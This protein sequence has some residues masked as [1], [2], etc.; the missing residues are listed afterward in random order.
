MSRTKKAA[1]LASDPAAPN[2]STAGNYLTKSSNLLDGHYYEAIPNSGGFADFGLTIDGALALAASRTDN[3]ALAQL[4]G[5]L[6]AQGKD[7]NGRTVDDW[8]GIG[9]QY[10]D[11][12]AI[13]KE[14]LLAE[15]TGYNPRAFGGHDLI[16]A[17]DQAVCTDREQRLSCGGGLPVRWLGCSSRPW[18]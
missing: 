18:A 13:A 7:G 9:S 17:L 16:A 11:S 6:N 15:A 8:T 3:S 14:A 1:A 5:W 12:G 4:V 10:V 2:L